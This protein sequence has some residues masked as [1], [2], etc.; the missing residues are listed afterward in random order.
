MLDHHIPS[1]IAVLASGWFVNGSHTIA[2]LAPFVKLDT[3][4][5]IY[6]DDGVT[7]TGRA[8]FHREIFHLLP[9]TD[10]ASPYQIE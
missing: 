5:Q 7:K 9:L 4:T 6:D 1:T 8:G 2:F 3:I 10:H